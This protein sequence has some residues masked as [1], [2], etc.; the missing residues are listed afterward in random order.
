MK[1]SNLPVTFSIICFIASFVIL[2][3]LI[4]TMIENS[5]WNGHIAINIFSIV[6]LNLISLFLINY[7]S[8]GKILIKISG[9]ILVLIVTFT[10]VLWSANQILPAKYARIPDHMSFEDYWANLYLSYLATLIVFGLSL[11]WL[12]ENLLKNNKFYF[13]FIAWLIGLA[14][15]AFIIVL[16]FAYTSSFTELTLGGIIANFISLAAGIALFIYGFFHEELLEPTPSSI[17]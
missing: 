14:T 6:L 15:L 11:I 2:T 7:S 9:F 8:K 16:T 4:K 17:E 3:D 12:G 5:I 1:N 10:Y 13:N